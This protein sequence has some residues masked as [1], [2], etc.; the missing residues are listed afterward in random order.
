M[1]PV[2][3]ETATDGSLGV[4]DSHSVLLACAKSGGSTYCG[5]LARRD[6]C[7]DYCTVRGG[8]LSD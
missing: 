8:R 6:R 3:R 5:L 7:L 1:T 2:D 4:L